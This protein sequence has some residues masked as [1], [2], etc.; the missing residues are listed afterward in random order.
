M[1]F[2]LITGASSGIGEEFVR[3]YAKKGHS[4]VITAR[5]EE[6]LHQL[7]RDL[8]NL[9]KITIHVI[10]QDLALPNAAEELYKKCQDKNL[11]INLLINDAGIGLISEFESQ[12]LNKIQEMIFINILALTKL[13]YLFLPQLKE[14]HG[15]ILNV[16][17]QASFE[18]TP[19]M[20]AY[21]ATKAYVLSFTQALR[22]ELQD[23]DVEV[24]ALC[25][26]PTYTNFFKRANTTSHV[27]QFKFRQPAEVVE[28]AIKGLESG[29]AITMP[30][31]ENNLWTFMTRF[32]P[33]S[34][35]AKVSQFMVNKK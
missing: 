18:P 20:A 26:G 34:A 29:K 7:A 6:K 5:N 2:T 24:T 14:N 28:E 19:Y 17:S 15:A 3:Q 21:G 32:M 11:R 22:V 13:C 16:A 27:I 8:M 23:T 35:L 9:Y 31:W 1:N 10:P 25:P 4:L 12:D 33:R 30:G